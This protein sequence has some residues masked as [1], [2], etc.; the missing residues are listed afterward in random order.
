MVAKSS[1][2]M[3]E[4]SESRV[5]ELACSPFWNQIAVEVE[6]AVAPK[7]VVAVN[8]KAAVSPAPVTKSVPATAAMIAP[9][10]VVLRMLSDEIPDMAKLVVVAL[11]KSEL[12]RSV[13][14]PRR[15]DATELRAPVMVLEPVTAKAEVVPL[16]RLKLRPV[17]RPV[18]DTEK[19]VEVAD[20]VD[21]PMAKSTSLVSP[22][23]VCTE[24]LA[25]GEVVPTPTAPVEE[26]RSLSV[27]PVEN[28][29]RSAPG[30]N[31]PVFPSELNPYVG[32]DA[33]PPVARIR[34]T[35]PAIVLEK[36]TVAAEAV[37]TIVAEP[38]T[39]R[40][41]VVVAPP[42]MVRPVVWPPAPIVELAS[43]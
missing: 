10:V 42:E 20:A 32:A 39:A 23:L 8:G 12:P 1:M 34:G 13:V 16:L 2:P 15:F 6:L 33:V 5:V 25:N 22:L 26:I 14:E 7:L 41:P 19:S 3:V 37:P 27:P 4:I 31:I 38:L 36:M 28:P 40:F 17:M 21:E 18:F 24:S 11:V 9:P 29:I 30:V 43:A 35:E